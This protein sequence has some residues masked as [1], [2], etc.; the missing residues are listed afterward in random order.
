MADTTLLLNG[1]SIIGDPKTNSNASNG[2]ELMIHDGTAVFENDDVVVMVVENVTVDGVLTDQSVVTKIIVYENAGDYFNDV[3]KYTYD[4]APG[5]GGDIETGRNTMGDRYLEFDA[6]TLTSTDAGAPILGDLAMVAGVD[7][8]GTLASQNGPFEVPTNEDIDLNGDGII[9]G[10]EIA[11]GAFTSA[12]NILTEE[13]LICF[14]A[15]T[16]I[17]TPMGPQPIETLCVGDRVNTL[18]DGPQKIAWIGGAAARGT[19]ANAPVRIRRGAIGNVR[20]L[21]VSQNH[22]MLVRGPQAELLFGEPEVLVAAKHLVDG[23]GIRIVPCAEVEYW[24]FLL[25]AHHIVF[26][27]ACATESLYPGQE[28]L[29][30]VTP[31]ERDEIVALFPELAERTCDYGL[32]RYA[33]KSFEARALRRTA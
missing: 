15:G 12:L 24:H 13:S 33:L 7:I 2:G 30:S 31:Q 9:S 4:A 22:R 28:S 10:D 16:L 29:K 3:P 21:W 5:G 8:L 26:A 6:S 18:D 23:D 27:E 32:S 11:D 19:G 25:D 1:F 17:E 14:A 20:D